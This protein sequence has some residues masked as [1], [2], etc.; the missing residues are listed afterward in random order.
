[1]SQTSTRHTFTVFL[2]QIDAPEPLDE[3][4]LLAAAQAFAAALA[5]TAGHEATVLRVS[6]NKDELVDVPTMQHVT[7]YDLTV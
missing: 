6:V 5:H 3:A 7:D 1:M 2:E 4:A